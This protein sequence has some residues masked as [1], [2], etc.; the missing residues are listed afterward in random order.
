MRQILLLLEIVIIMLLF[1]CTNKSKERETCNVE[2]S[3]ISHIELDN[4]S[5]IKVNKG[6]Q[7]YEIRNRDK[8]KD[9]LATLKKSH[10]KYIK[11]GSKDI[12]KIYDNNQNVLI[13]CFFKD[14]MFKLKGVVYQTDQFLFE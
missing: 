5:F 8:L 4:V 2:L 14:D 7:E 13:E 11:F 10:I 3:P 12:F 1:G 6:R 9:I